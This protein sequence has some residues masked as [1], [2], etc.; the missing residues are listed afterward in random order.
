MFIYISYHKTRPLVKVTPCL[1]AS[2]N[3]PAFFIKIKSKMKTPQ[4]H[5]VRLNKVVLGNKNT[6]KQY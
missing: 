3:L 2:G 1:L 5:F 6:K 4:H